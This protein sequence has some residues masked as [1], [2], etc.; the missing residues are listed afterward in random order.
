LAD[1]NRRT[2]AV[3]GILAHHAEETHGRLA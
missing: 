2:I 3:N 1:D